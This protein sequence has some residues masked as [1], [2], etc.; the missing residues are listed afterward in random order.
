MRPPVFVSEHFEGLK[1][2]L[3]YIKAFK[4]KIFVIKLGGEVCE[5]E[6]ALAQVA[7]QINTLSLLGVQIVIVHGG[8]TQVTKLAEQMG[9][10]SKFING[11]R[12]TTP[13]MLKIV[14]MAVKGSINTDIVAMLNKHN[15]QAVGVTGADA[16]MV[17]A[18][19]R[20]PQIINNQ[21]VDFGE[22]GDV[23][24][25]D[26]SLIQ[27][28][29]EK[30]YI[31]VI[32]C[33]SVGADGAV[34]NTNGDTI[35]TQIAIAL[36]AEKIIYVTA[37]DGVMKDLKDKSTLFSQLNVAEVKELISSSVISGGM[38]PKLENCI[39]AISGAVNRAHIINGFRSDALLFE[40]FTNEGCGT[41]VVA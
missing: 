14:K 27:V 3:P 5:S 17:K 12:I 34:Y 11:K 16:M 23:V 10:A 21:E 38:I 4:G 8:G 9:V 37:V 29:N 13:E 33:F 28:L 15:L 22:V 1:N 36:K 40:V 30:K 26:T 24:T 39:Q 25:V 20:S 19:K 32:S 18:K 41:M 6:N 7:E 31:P 35:A 2:A